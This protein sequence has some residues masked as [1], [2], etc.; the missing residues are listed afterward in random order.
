M[1]VEFLSSCA[2]MVEFLLFQ[3]SLIILVLLYR[4][5]LNYLA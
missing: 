2:M 1:M 5:T 4:R 3:L